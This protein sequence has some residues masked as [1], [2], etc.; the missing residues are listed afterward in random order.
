MN[1]TEYIREHH[2]VPYNILSELTKINKK[3]EKIGKKIQ[4]AYYYF[5]IICIAN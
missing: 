4:I 3:Y 2:H 5:Q 1:N